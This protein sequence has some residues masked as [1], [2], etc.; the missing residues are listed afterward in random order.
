VS[1]EQMGEK[2]KTEDSKLHHFAVSSSVLVGFGFFN[3]VRFSDFLVGF[4][5]LVWFSVSVFRKPRFQFGF[6][7]L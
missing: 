5:Q 4:S 1:Y 6:W 3:R 7:Y 2:S